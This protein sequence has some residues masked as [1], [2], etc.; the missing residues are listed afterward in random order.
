MRLNGKQ[1]KIE[2]RSVA[3]QE[4]LKELMMGG[5]KSQVPCLKI[6]EADRT[7]VQWMYESDD[8]LQYIASNNLVE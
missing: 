7:A 8:I 4:N 1:H 5:G 3:E 6:V 2:L